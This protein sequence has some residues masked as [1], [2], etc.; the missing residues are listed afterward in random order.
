MY[1]TK[2]MTSEIAVLVRRYALSFAE[3]CLLLPKKRILFG[4]TDVGL[5]RLM[6]LGH[7]NVGGDDSKPNKRSKRQSSIFLLC[8]PLDQWE[9]Q[10]RECPGL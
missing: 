1:Q 9:S 8:S 3:F 10:L 5:G 6:S 2:R 4:I 7:W